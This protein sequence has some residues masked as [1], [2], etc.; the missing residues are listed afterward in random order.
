MICKQ[1]IAMHFFQ[2]AKITLK[3]KA[4]K[5]HCDFMFFYH[6]KM[7]ITVIFTK[8]TKFAKNINFSNRENRH[9]LRTA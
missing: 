3:L 9:H 6:F 1:I 4:L 8:S 5:F 7:P 2:T